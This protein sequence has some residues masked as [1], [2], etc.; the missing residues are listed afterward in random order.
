MKKQIVGNETSGNK[1]ENDDPENNEPYNNVLDNCKS[2]MA[3]WDY[4][5]LLFD[6]DRTL[7]DFDKSE[8]IA[9]RQTFEEYGIEMSDS[10]HYKYAEINHSYW[11]Q[12]ELGLI[13]RER[14]IYE[15]FE[16]LFMQEEM[17]INYIE[18]EDRYQYLLSE[19]AYLIEGALEVIQDLSMKKDIYIVTNGVRDTQ[20]KRLVSTGLAELVKDIF[21]SEEIGYQKPAK[22]YFDV[23]F[24]RI[25]NFKKESAI[26]IGDSLTSDIK[27]GNN[28]GI[29]TC[30]YNPARHPKTAEVNVTHE[31]DCL[32]SLRE[33]LIK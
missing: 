17:D 3:S 25:E 18:F 12:H 9:L 11:F 26:I 5:I 10:L 29:D 27:G 7:L 32:E 19:S 16:S 30:W 31:I 24:K 21:I 14:L 22:E 13:S 8:Y 6:A 4:D 28:A 1:S 23:V 33:V 2:V 15:R 20:M